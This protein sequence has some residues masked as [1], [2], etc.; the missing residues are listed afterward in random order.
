MPQPPPPCRTGWTTAKQVGG[1]V[2]TFVSAA[3]LLAIAIANLVI[4]RAVWCS[5][6]EVRRGGSLN[7]DAL[8]LLLAGR[9]L[10]AR[11]FR[12]LFRAITQT[13][14][15][16]PLGLL[17]GLGFD[18]A[19][20]VGLLGISATQAAHGMSPWQA[21]V[22]P[23]LFTA[24]MALVDTTDSVLMVGAYGWAFINPLR[25]LWYNLTITA[26][27]VLIA[28][29]I[30]GIEALGLIGDRLALNGPFWNAIG[31]LNDSIGNLG[32]AVVGIF[33]LCWA[34]SSIVYRLKG[35][36]LVRSEFALKGQSSAGRNVLARP[37][38]PLLPWRSP[39][40]KSRRQASAIVA[41]IVGAFW[42]RLPM[43]ADPV[44]IAESGRRSNMRRLLVAVSPLVLAAA[45]A[46]CSPPPPAP[47]PVAAPPPP[48]PRSYLVFF[49]WNKANL[50]DRAMQI[51]KEAADN[52]M[53]M[54]VSKIDVNGYTDTSGSPQYNQKLSVRRG[55]AVAA[56]LAKDGVPQ[57]SITVQGFGE[58]HLLVP[59]G[60][61]VR[62]PQNRRV[63]IITP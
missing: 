27:S 29:L 3:F 60:P 38:G 49:D 1:I 7:E 50:S 39:A 11:L 43:P 4:L 63:E 19:T 5:F 61:G 46:A 15:M 18:T 6:R 51:I 40:S 12:P 56:E 17:F 26:A 21:M 9:G 30:G 25:K 55:Q 54:H 52:S 14:H 24:G 57:G 31:R 62:E 45:L 35:Y 59:T 42:T 22:F 28:L 37:C 48:P 53:K 44:R 8:N 34:V 23:A 13:W 47:T 36:D 20:E 2:G 10:L 16:Y 33:I 58:T 32:F 41:N